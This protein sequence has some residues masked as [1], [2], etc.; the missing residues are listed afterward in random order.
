MQRYLLGVCLFLLASGASTSCMFMLENDAAQTFVDLLLN[1]TAINKVDSATT[2]AIGQWL[3]AEFD[4]QQYEALPNAERKQFLYNLFPDKHEKYF[5]IGEVKYFISKSSLGQPVLYQYVD[6]IPIFRPLPDFAAPSSAN[7]N[8][9]S[10]NVHI[11]SALSIALDR[12]SRAFY[13]LVQSP[14]FKSSCVAAAT[15]IAVYYWTNWTNKSKKERRQLPAKKLAISAAVLSGVVSFSY[16][17]R[18]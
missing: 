14:Y 3:N 18:H 1:K 11:P 13:A 16:F 9:L 15:G 6:E 8:E 17:D 2:Q 10:E 12:T 5:T 7:P 4:M